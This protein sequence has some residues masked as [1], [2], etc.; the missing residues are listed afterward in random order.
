MLFIL[1][2][3]YI[4]LLPFFCTHTRAHICFLSFATSPSLNSFYFYF[5]W[6]THTKYLCMM[7]AFAAFTTHTYTSLFICV[8]NAMHTL[9][10]L[11]Y[12]NLCK[13]ENKNAHAHTRKERER[14]VHRRTFATRA[15][16]KLKEEK[17]RDERIKKA[18]RENKCGI[19]SFHFCIIL[20]VLIVCFIHL[21]RYIYVCSC[22]AVVIYAPAHILDYK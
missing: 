22:V 10:T 20:W 6:S 1:Y 21:Y 13:N 11:I 16:F 12:R 9:F 7:Y 8:V 18:A 14:E 19:R 4:S 3:T 5:A 2:P 15:Q 17:R